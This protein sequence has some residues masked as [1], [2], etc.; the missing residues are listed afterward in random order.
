MSKIV[1]AMLASHKRHMAIALVTCRGARLHH[2]KGHEAGG[3]GGRFHL[4]IQGPLKHHSQLGSARIK[5]YK[6]MMDI[7]G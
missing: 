7:D 6:W 1:K 3:T 2:L 5:N 4:T